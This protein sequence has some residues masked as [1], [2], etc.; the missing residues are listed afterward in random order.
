MLNF[1][2]AQASSLV[3]DACRITR[4]RLFLD[5]AHNEEI[6]R[7]ALAYRALPKEKFETVGTKTDPVALRT[8]VC[9][10]KRYVYAVNRD[11][12]PIEVE[13]SLDRS[14]ESLINLSTGK[15]MRSEN[16]LRLTLAPYELRSFSMSPEIKIIGFVATPPESIASALLE[17]AKGALSDIQ[18]L[19]DS[20]YFIPGMEQMGQ[21]IK[22]AMAEGR[23]AWLRRALSGYY[24]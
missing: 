17:N 10:N 21:D 11:Y 2:V 19:S 1:K 13:I 15:N 12:Y 5:K 6:A 18:A 16:L 4:G 14:P 7:F 9:D 22:S 23:L 20:G 24:P 3:L 8:L